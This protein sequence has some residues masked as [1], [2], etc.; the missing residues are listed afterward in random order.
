M[1]RA[2]D[3][4]EDFGFLQAGREVV[5]CKKV[6]DAPADVTVT[7]ASDLIPIGIRASFSG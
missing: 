5:A 2:E 1:V 6:V 7:R 3:G 4:G